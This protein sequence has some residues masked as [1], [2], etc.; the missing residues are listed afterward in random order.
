[1]VLT[2]ERACELLAYDKTT[3]VLTWR[4]GPRAGNPAG[5]VDARGY[6]SVGIDQRQHRAH[7]I[8]WLMETGTWPSLHIDHRN[9]KR[10]DNRWCNLRLATPSQ[11]Q[12]NKGKHPRNTSGCKGVMK[13][14]QRKKWRAEPEKKWSAAI[15]VNGKSKHLGCFATR[16]AAA[17]AYREECQRVHGAFARSA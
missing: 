11:N 7:R 17:K 12:C 13:L 8:A 9:R 5:S 1:M 14:P 4:I 3:G 16:A 10:C 15:K 6:I 2:A